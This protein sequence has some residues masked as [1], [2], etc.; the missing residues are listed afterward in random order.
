[1]R[2]AGL[3]ISSLI[4]LSLLLAACQARSPASHAAADTTAV[5]QDLERMLTS[6]YQ[7]F[8]DG[9]VPRWSAEMVDSVFLTAADPSPSLVTRQAVQEKMEREFG[10][11]RAAGITLSITPQS[12]EIWVSE[13]GRSA[14]S[15]YE[16]DYV[17]TYQKK[18]YP[19]KLRSTIVFAHDSVGWRILAAQYSRPLGMDTLFMAVVN[20]RIPAVPPI[21][22]AASPGAGE[23]S[24]QFRRDV[25]DISKAT[26]SANATIVLP[27]TVAVGQQEARSALVEWLGRPGNA[28]IASGIRAALAPS[29][30]TG[31]VATNLNVPIYAGPESGV[32]PIRALVVYHLAGDH[33][34][35]VQAHFAVGLPSR[36]G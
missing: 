5:R 36:G 16:L 35:I 18:S 26:L 14:A 9:D 6:H 34:E 4:A 23:L 13:D 15:T 27:G 10:P 22:A 32:A 1:M 7:A 24:D 17:S 25:A 28:Q 20:G 29:N 8:Q 30:T 12:H 3:R 31:Y 21:E 11:A 33:W 19:V 2:L